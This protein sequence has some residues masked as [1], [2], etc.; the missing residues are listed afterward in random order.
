MWIS[1]L[2]ESFYDTEKSRNRTG[3][4]FDEVSDNNIKSSEDKKRRIWTVDYVLDIVHW[5]RFI[6]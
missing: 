5:N 3:Y 2:F 1:M 6:R 4:S